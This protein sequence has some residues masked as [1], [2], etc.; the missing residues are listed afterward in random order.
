M[1]ELLLNLLGSPEIKLRGKEIQTDR[2]KA[3]ALLTYLALDERR[4]SRE[5]L[6]AFFWGDYQQG[7][8]LAYLRRTLW[9]LGQMLE[10]EWIEADRDTVCFIAENCRIDVKNLLDA[11][12]SGIFQDRDG[13]SRL[14]FV[15]DTYRGDFLEGFTLR[16]APEF[17]QWQLY[18]METLRQT[19]SNLLANI[20]RT[21]EN[22]GDADLLIKYARRRVALDPLNE[23]A[24]YTLID[25]YAKF[26]L[27][28][29]ALRQYQDFVRLMKVELGTSPEPQT[30]E[31]YDQIR[32]YQYPSANSQPLVSKPRRPIEQPGRATFPRYPDRFIGRQ[33]DQQKIFQI[34]ADPACRL[35]TILGPGGIGKT[36]LAV[37]TGRKLFSEYQDGVFFIPL[38]AISQPDQLP[39]AIASAIG[40]VIRSEESP[41]N[42][43]K[44]PHQQ[45]LDYLASKHILLIL[46]NFEQ[47]IP[48]AETLPAMLAADEHITILITSRVRLQLEEEWILPLDGLEIYASQPIESEG[49]QSAAVELFLERSKRFSASTQ[50]TRQDW[51]PAARICEL[52][53]GIPLGIELAAAWTRNLPISELAA[54]I[55]HSLDILKASTRNVPEKHRSMRAVFESSWNLLSAED[56][57]I[58]ARLSLFRGSFD[59][60]DAEAALNASLDQLL[61]LADQS[62]L[63]SLDSGRYEIHELLRQFAY[64][65]FESAPDKK[66]IEIQF[67]LY[68]LEE[69]KLRFDD[70]AGSHLHQGLAYID[71]EFETIRL[72]WQLGINHSLWQELNDAVVTLYL[73]LRMRGRFQDAW[74]LF[75]SAANNIEQISSR[76]PALV[77]FTGFVLASRAFYCQILAH[78]QEPTGYDCDELVRK[79][80][81]ILIDLPEE[82]DQH[83]CALILDYG[84]GVLPNEIALERIDLARRHFAKTGRSWEGAIADFARAE[85]ATYFEQDLAAGETFYKKSLDT[86]T[87]IGSIWY[88]AMSLKGLS[89]L[90]LS[91]GRYPLALQ[92]AE[93]CRKIIQDLDVLLWETIDVQL[94]LGRIEVALGN[95]QQ[96]I[97]YY[98]DNLTA[99]EQLGDL[100]YTAIHHDCLGYAYSLMGKIEPASQKYDISLGIYRRAGDKHGIGMALCNLG[101]L[102]RAKDE[103]Q[104]AISYYQEGYQHL[105]SVQGLWGM[106]VALKKLGQVE[107]QI[108]N[109][110]FAIETLFRALKL[111]VLLERDPETLEILTALISYF[112]Q[113]NSTEHAQALIELIGTHPATPKIVLDQLQMIITRLEPKPQP[114]TFVYRSP[115]EAALKS[116]VLYEPEAD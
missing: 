104:L 89:A 33:V 40:C 37:E 103:F 32:T 46:D 5:K 64:E 52:V 87:S 96:A 49:S 35:L 7:S 4:H 9:E 34:L 48:S 47:I 45:L 56:R 8:A 76:S 57:S 91:T 83:V 97:D 99:L 50:F 93:Q 113:Q 73:Y 78:R 1:A 10:D 81:A 6:A 94:T 38:T 66:N 106:V 100:L 74:K 65:K 84:L 105:E 14:T 20:C 12:N 51:L 58:F 70:L 15:A 21:A 2:R 108:G 25:S 102:A 95:Y 28:N 19:F 109:R 92:Y 39:L 110:Q 98:L 90:A 79:S 63:R 77:S 85:Y 68:F 16:D 62:L 61:H 67:S 107:W 42:P 18:Q 80:Y 101:D 13:L 36:R 71:Q 24:Q 30:R 82:H 59:R 41:D 43:L 88:Q 114:S 111:A 115:V 44:S 27:R 26:E 72:A 86:F 22:V 112:Y 3:V 54:E 55:T 11:V 75:E 17:D 29:L 116:L 69:V 53:G 60:F 31:L 23:T